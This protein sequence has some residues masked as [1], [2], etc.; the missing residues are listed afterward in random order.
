MKSVEQSSAKRSPT[1]TAW[2]LM[3]VYTLAHTDRQIVSILAEP[4]KQE[5]GLSDSQVGVLIG[6]SFVVVYTAL[7]VPIARLSERINRVWLLAACLSVWSIFTALGSLAQNF[8]HLFLARVGVGVGEAGTNPASY[9]LIADVASRKDR[10]KLLSIFNLG[11]PIGSFLG[12]AAGG[13][14]G[15]VFGW[16]QA[17]L[18]VG[19]P[20][21]IVAIFLVLSLRD[22]RHDQSVGLI[23]KEAKKK[24]I[25]FNEDFLEVL[26]KRSYLLMLGGMASIIFLN[27]G[28]V[29]FYGSFF[30]RNHLDGLVEVSGLIQDHFGF[31]VKPL[32]ILGLIIGSLT[33]I[34]GA[35]GTVL[36]GWLGDRFGGADPRGY[37][38]VPIFGC[39]LQFPF[40]IAALFVPSFLHSVA[41]FAVPA[42]LTATYLSPIIAAMVGVVRP[43]LRATATAISTTVAILIGFGCGPAFTGM[44]SDVYTS[45]FGDSGQ[46]VRF[47]LMTSSLSVISAAGFFALARLHIR[48]DF[49]G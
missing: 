4:I 3:V 35:F 10:A 29:S 30:L 11:L 36:G 9:S 48:K 44:L 2:L 20:G 45:Q 27:Y 25:S 43:T 8:T 49:E 37:L 28:K 12:L 46:G 41:L 38:I 26:S 13:V 42:F 19:M 21:V 31:S 5:L 23:Q 18:L 14:V 24:T 47:A 33:G 34:F 32:A 17:F 15:S 22:P 7:S 40:L 39:L 1:Y 16:R 6:L